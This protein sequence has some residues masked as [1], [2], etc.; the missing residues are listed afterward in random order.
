MQ[1][2]EFTMDNTRIFKDMEKEK[3]FTIMEMY[4]K[5]NGKMIREV[6]KEN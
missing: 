5:E 1:M 4:T 6:E 3:W 2:E